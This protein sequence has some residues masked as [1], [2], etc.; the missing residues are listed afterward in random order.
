MMFKIINGMSFSGNWYP[1]HQPFAI[2]LSPFRF[3]L[4]NVNINQIYEYG[5]IYL[6]L[7]LHPYTF[8]LFVTYAHPSV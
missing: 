4:R 3:T 1:P 8:S 7:H 5:K 2:L 6:T